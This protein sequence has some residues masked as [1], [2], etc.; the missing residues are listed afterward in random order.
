MPTNALFEPLILS[1]FTVANETTEFNLSLGDLIICHFICQFVTSLHLFN[2]ADIAL[3][4]PPLATPTHNQLVSP[5]TTN[6]NILSTGIPAPIKVDGL[7][8]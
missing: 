7:E 4:S 6:S 2:H 8:T 1:T 3:I 5:L